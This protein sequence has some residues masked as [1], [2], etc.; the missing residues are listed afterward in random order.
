MTMRQFLA[1]VALGEIDVAQRIPTSIIPVN[2]RD[3]RR[4][5]AFQAQERAELN[6]L[7]SLMAGTGNPGAT[8]PP[9]VS[10]PGGQSALVVEGAGAIPLVLAA[11]QDSSGSPRTGSGEHFVFGDPILPGSDGAFTDVA[12]KFIFGDPNSPFQTASFPVA[13]RGDDQPVSLPFVDVTSQGLSADCN[14]TGGGGW[15]AQDRV[16]PSPEYASPIYPLDAATGLRKPGGD[17]RTNQI[18]LSQKGLIALAAQGL[19]ATQILEHYFHFIPPMVQGVEISSVKDSLVASFQAATTNNARRNLFFFGNTSGPSILGSSANNLSNPHAGAPEPAALIMRSAWLRGAVNPAA[20]ASTTRFLDRE[21]RG[22]APFDQPLGVAAF[23]NEDVGGTQL[24]NDSAATR[25]MVQF[26]LTD[27][28]IPLNLWTDLG[29]TVYIFSEVTET[30]SAGHGGS[31]DDSLFRSLPNK[32]KGAALW[33]AILNPGLVNARLKG[34][35]VRLLINSVNKEN[36]LLVL[37]SNPASM[38]CSVPGATWF[39]GYEPGPDIL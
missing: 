26:S 35:Q 14:V 12:W 10:L 11:F 6:E 1:S 39:S 25:G 34:H 37:D 24:P 9:I 17:N 4:R 5:E 23:F 19:S 13:T 7:L 16:E 22:C 21:V 3:A 28:A 20:P 32:N 33:F 8:P 31:P 30:K 15:V 2:V 36:N 38:A 27:T 18:G 29:G